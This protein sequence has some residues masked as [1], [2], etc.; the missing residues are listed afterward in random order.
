MKNYIFSAIIF[1][2]FATI[3]VQYKLH[4]EET[5]ILEENFWIAYHWQDLKEGMTKADVLKTLNF[6]PEQISNEL[7][8]SGYQKYLIEDGTLRLHW[9]NNKPKQ[10]GTLRELLGISYKPKTSM[11]M[12]LFLDFDKD[13]KLKAIYYGG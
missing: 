7:G 4:K 13:E 10:K 1:L 3:L 6:P 12:D 2:L 8:G 9:S 5:V 11:D